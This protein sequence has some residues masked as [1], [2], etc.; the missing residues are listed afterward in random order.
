MSLLLTL[1]CCTPTQACRALT[2][3]TGTDT[4]N[5]S[6]ASRLGLLVDLQRALK[7]HRLN[8]ALQEQAC[9]AI[10]SLTFNIDNETPLPVGPEVQKPKKSA[11]TTTKLSGY[12]HRAFLSLSG[13]TKP[14]QPP[15][16]GDDHCFANGDGNG[17]R[18]VLAELQQTMQAHAGS[19]TLQEQACRALNNLT[20]TEDGVNCEEAVRLGLLSDLQC[21][22]QTHP[23]SA[24]VQGLAL[25]VAANIVSATPSSFETDGKCEPPQLGV[26]VLPASP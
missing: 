14:T 21:C 3:M 1:F 20:A 4:R 15:S 5:K 11:G 7:V 17:M 19:A 12:F 24:D 10:W 9:W 23:A 2:N 13:T 16:G 25:A 8:E 18:S 22:L 26:K 6:E